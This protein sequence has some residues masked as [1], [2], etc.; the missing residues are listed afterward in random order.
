[1]ITPLSLLL[2]AGLAA[3]FFTGTGLLSPFKSL[4]KQKYIFII[5]TCIYKYE[6]GINI[7]NDQ[8]WVFFAVFKE[9]YKQ[10]KSNI[11]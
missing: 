11:K 7:K 9:V 5:Y 10:F 8:K 4:K 6:K 3:A 2:S 1:M